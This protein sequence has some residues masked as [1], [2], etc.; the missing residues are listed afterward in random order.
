[1]AL[2]TEDGHLLMQLFHRKIFPKRVSFKSLNAVNA[3]IQIHELRI[4]PV[5]K[6]VLS[7]RKETQ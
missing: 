2:L 3:E 6:D 7:P 4:C 1:M 5:N